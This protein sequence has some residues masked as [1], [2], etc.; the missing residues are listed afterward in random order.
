MCILIVKNRI[1]LP[2]NVLI[3][4]DIFDEFAQW[5]SRARR[6]T[7][8]K[9][10]SRMFWIQI[11]DTN[12]ACLYV[13]IASNRNILPNLVI[14][15]DFSDPLPCTIRISS[16]LRMWDPSYNSVKKFDIDAINIFLEFVFDIPFPSFW[17]FTGLFIFWSWKYFPFNG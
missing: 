8:S 4:D 12:R 5:K 2:P 6:V 3:F 16:L 9:V 17:N 15:N 13:Y 7:R 14:S 1:F 10:G 11:R